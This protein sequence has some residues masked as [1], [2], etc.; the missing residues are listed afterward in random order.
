M[1]IAIHYQ[2]GNNFSPYW[3]KYCEENK[4]PHKIVNCYESN[5]IEQIR[6]CDALMWHI[7]NFDYRDQVF[8]KYVFKAA[9]EMGIIV[10]PK[11]DDVWHYD[12]KVAQKYLLEAIDAPMV[13]SY[14]FYDKKTAREWVNSTTFPKVFKLRKGSG[15]KNVNLVKTKP[16]AISIINKM[17]GKGIQPLSMFG[18][19]QERLMKYKQGKEN[20]L[21]LLKGII[22][23]FIGTPYLRMSV[24]EKGYVYFQDFYPDNLFDLRIYTIGNRVFGVKRMTRDNDFRASGSDKMI[25]DKEQLDPKCIQIARETSSKLNSLTLAYD[26]I[27]DRNHNPKIIEISCVFNP[28]RFYDVESFATNRNPGYWDENNNWQDKPAEP[29]KWM[30]EEV[31]NKFSSSN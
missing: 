22:R 31:Y 17:F 25:Y 9:E 29:M 7:N 12:D 24:R 28:A 1:L 10:F 21:G 3:K 26:F 11:Y 14:A 30:I 8:A 20:L 27:Y 4:V 6:D 5:I 18:Q 2:P 15:S 23:L 13:E 16:Q 19:L